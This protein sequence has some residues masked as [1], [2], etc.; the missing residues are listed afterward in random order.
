MKR[1]IYPLFSWQ[2]ERTLLIHD[3]YTHFYLNELTFRGPSR[4]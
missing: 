1:Q 2:I 4:V 3:Y